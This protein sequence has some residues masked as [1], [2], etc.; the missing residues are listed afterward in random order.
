MIHNTKSFNETY[1]VGSNDNLSIKKIVD[2]V[3]K[4]IQKKINIEYKPMRKNET[5][6]FVPDI[7]KINHDIKMMELTDIESGIRKTIK[8]YLKNN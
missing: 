1:N 7:K 4:I 8:W 5:N 2:I 3:L 6:N